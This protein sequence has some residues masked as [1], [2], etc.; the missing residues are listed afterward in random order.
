MTRLAWLDYKAALRERKVLIAVAMYGY[1]ILAV[2]ALL[3]RPPAHVQEAVASWFGTEDPFALF[4]YLW[5]DIAMN[6]LLAVLAVVLA[7][8]VVTRERELRLLPVLWSKPI[9]P[10]RYFLVRAGSAMAVMATLYVGAHLV[11]VGWFAA[12]IDGFR[13]GAF[14]AS[15]S[16][17]VFAAVFATAL[18]ATVSVATGRRGLSALLSMLVLLMLIGAAFVGFYNPAWKTASLLNPMSLGV[19]AL[20]HLDA[21]APAHVL[22]PIAALVGVI[23]ATLGVGALLARRLEA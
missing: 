1:A 17:H 4:L 9:T 6:K 23:A 8:G 13:V 15:M 7:G 11:A 5:T 16:L 19:Q 2:P 12:S 20:A 21:L 18:A 22:L 3:S 10:A 14:F